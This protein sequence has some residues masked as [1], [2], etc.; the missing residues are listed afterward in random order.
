[1]TKIDNS[2]NYPQ[3]PPIQKILMKVIACVFLL[4]LTVSF[5]IYCPIISLE[6]KALTKSH[7]F[8]F[9]TILTPVDIPDFVIG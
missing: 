3:F 9:F 4:L 6:L 7:L 8:G 1:M 2:K 5:Q